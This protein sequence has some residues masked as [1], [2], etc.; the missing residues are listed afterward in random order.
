MSDKYLYDVIY[1]IKKVVD[2]K[3]QMKRHTRVVAA[4]IASNAELHEILCEDLQHASLHGDCGL[5]DHLY[6]HA[7]GDGASAIRNASI[8]DWMFKFSGNQLRIKTTD[9]GVKVI[10]LQK[11]WS[12]DKFDLDGA[13]KTPFW[14][15]PE[16]GAQ[17]F[18]FDDFIKTIRGY[19]KKLERADEADKFNGDK[20]AISATITKIADYAEQQKR[21]LTDKQ[22]GLVHTEEKTVEM[23]ASLQ[24]VSQLNNSDAQ[25]DTQ[26]EV[27]LPQVA[28][29]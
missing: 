15:R 12:A 1:V 6:H 21:R 3:V 5:L 26:E 27:E 8:K 29:G 16:K 4:I 9:A 14:S 22:L 7:I 10:G 11:G 17:A 25:T 23:P 24:A 19:V 28:V 20:T 13:E 18:S 2:K